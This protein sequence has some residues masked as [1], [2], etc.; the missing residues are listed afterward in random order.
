MKK[1]F[2]FIALLCLITSISMAQA[3]EHKPIK[4]LQDT[5]NAK[6]DTAKVVKDTLWKKQNSVIFTTEQSYF[7]NWSAGGFSTFAFSGYYKSFF[8]YK[9]GKINWNNN[10][11][12]GYGQMLQ[13]ITGNGFKDTANHFQ[14]SE[15][16]IELNSVFG[17]KAFAAWN[18][19][20]LL[21]LKSQFDN[22]Y[23][24]NSLISSTFS[25]TVLTSSVG[26]EYKKPSYSVLFSFLTGKTTYVGDDR[27]LQSGI[28]GFTQPDKHWYFSLGSFVKFFFQKD[29]F[30]N[31]NLMA[32]VEFFYDYSKPL[33]DIDVNTEIFL[34][35]KIN[36]YLTAF[37]SVQAIIDY[38]F[39]TS[40]QFK[41]RFGLSIPINF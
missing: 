15:D 41:E 39:N 12:L 14:K 35:M 21:N 1:T 19:S 28:L 9:K 2:G 36:K 40:L 5:T 10:I 33:K 3:N 27:L 37:I 18:Y 16:K 17:Y 26:L 4:I 34:N 8:N 29:I 24:D 7:N 23:K 11:D 38:D 20:F 13:D 31:I 22:G 6:K 30:T 32:K 25:P